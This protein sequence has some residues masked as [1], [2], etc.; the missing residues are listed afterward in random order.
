MT[1]LAKLSAGGYYC[2]SSKKESYFSISL[3]KTMADPPDGPSPPA[4]MRFWWVAV[5]PKVSGPAF[6]ERPES[7]QRLILEKFFYG[8]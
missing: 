6:F 2:I 8:A 1:A 3:P 4:V 5:C 7:L